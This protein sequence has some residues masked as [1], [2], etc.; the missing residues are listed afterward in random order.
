M[1]LTLVHVQ[2]E[3][4]R[5]DDFIAATRANARG[6]VQEPGNRRFDVLQDPAD[7]CHF[8]LYEAYASAADAAAHKQTAHYAAWRD[9]VAD[10]MA[11][12]RQGIP[13]TVLF[14]DD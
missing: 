2:V 9:S 10:M 3:P 7:P 8:I 1:H 14:P 12:P 13:M 11:A 6:S 5:L 4:Q